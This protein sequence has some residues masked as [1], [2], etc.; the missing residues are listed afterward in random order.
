MTD[1]TQIIQEFNNQVSNIRIKIDD[2]LFARFVD[3]SPDEVLQALQDQVN[4]ALDETNNLLIN[5]L[6]E[7]NQE[8]RATHEVLQRIL[9]RE[10][11]ICTCC[12]G[13][14]LSTNTR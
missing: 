11:K 9:T 2:H 12:K 10:G 7:I 3:G 5:V 6:D 1:L 13:E 8:I 4:S 14:Y